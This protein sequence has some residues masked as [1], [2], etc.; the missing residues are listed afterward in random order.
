VPAFI[1][2]DGYEIIGGAHCGDAGQK[3]CHGKLVGV[4]L[5]VGAAVLEDKELALHVSLTR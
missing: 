2:G 1:R 4:W 3:A 5:Q